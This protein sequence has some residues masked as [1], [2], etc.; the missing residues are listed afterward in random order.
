MSYYF[1][2]FYGTAINFIVSVTRVLFLCC[3]VVCYVEQCICSS[4]LKYDIVVW[5]IR[6]KIMKIYPKKCMPVKYV[7]RII[8][9]LFVS[10][11]I[12]LSRKQSCRETRRLS[13]VTSRL[14][15]ELLKD[16]K[17]YC[18]LILWTHLWKRWIS[19][20]VLVYKLG[21]QRRTTLIIFCCKRSL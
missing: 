6:N 15:W 9:H 8:S 5:I 4:K 18:N 11:I 1:D 3:F 16:K 21:A 14:I 2:S 7:T 13:R 19:K 17:L 12:S 10:S 20:L